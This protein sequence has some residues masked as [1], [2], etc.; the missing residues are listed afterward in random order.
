MLKNAFWLK[1]N[2]DRK[3][4]KVLDASWY[5]PN[6]NR[7]AKKEFHYSRIPGA[8]YFDIDDISDKKSK[9]FISVSLSTIKLH[10][11]LKTLPVYQG[12]AFC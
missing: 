6:I 3:N 7:D 11:S 4:I 10:P 5:L 9:S 12:S 1:K 8:I 2:I